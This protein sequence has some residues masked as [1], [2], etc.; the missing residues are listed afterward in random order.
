MV[1]VFL[2]LLVTSASAVTFMPTPLA[3]Y[4]PTVP[5]SGE[6]KTVT[7]FS[8]K[9]FVTKM[10]N[11][12]LKKADAVDVYFVCNVPVVAAV[13]QDISVRGIPYYKHM[14]MNMG[15]II[16]T[17]CAKHMRSTLKKRYRGKIDTSSNPAFEAIP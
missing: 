14:K 16:L 11:L 5:Q 9:R 6:W 2:F 3:K 4:L 7:S 1:R 13:Y 17:D 10:L 8:G 12:P 15:A